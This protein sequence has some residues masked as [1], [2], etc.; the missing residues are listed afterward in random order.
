MDGALP[1]KRL[2][3]AE[4]LTWAEGAP[5]GRYELFRGEVVEMAPER[6]RHN[7]LKFAA[8]TALRDAIRRSS[9]QATAY[10][11]GMTVVID[12]STAREPDALV[13]FTPIAL[14][15]LIADAPAIVV[16]VASPSSEGSDIATKLA[17]YFS[18]A[19]IQHYLIVDLN[20]L[21]IHHQRQADGK[22]LT[23]IIRDGDITL[24]PPGLVI[25][26]DEMVPKLD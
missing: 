13:Q 9:V 12:D 7:L 17:E 2:T 23:R 3:V 1:N 21:V 24:E 14:D 20:A 25:P 8:A 22:I 18:V 11:D 16:E 26:Y 19:S 6:A 4:Y 10:T 5:A 15:S